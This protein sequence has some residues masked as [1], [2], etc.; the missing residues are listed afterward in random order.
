MKE[1]AE[2]NIHEPYA[3]ALRFTSDGKTLITTGMDNLI[4]LWSVGDWS[5]RNTITGHSKSANTL[6]LNPGESILASGS[7]DHT[8]RLWSFPDGDPQQT[9]EHRK[10][11]VA[12]VL[13]TTDG[14]L[15]ASGWYGGYV[16]VWSL[17]DNEQILSIKANDRHVNSLDISQDN[18]IMATS[19]IGDVIRLW[20]LPSGEPAGEL[21]GHKSAVWSLTFIEGGSTL[22]SMGY[23][24]DVVLWDM[25][26]LK[27]IK[28]FSIEGEDP[29]GV[30]VSPDESLAAV[31]MQGQVE[32]RQMADWSLEETLPVSSKVVHA[33]AFSPDGITIVA[34]GGDGKLRVWSDT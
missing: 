25:E 29:R 23:E 9:F 11:T 31:P 8:V 20:N 14:K 34:S 4:K 17:D 12:A 18:T 7:S 27:E 21:S 13:F 28:R 16:A 19:G 30:V 10:Q 15:L 33:A 6:D 26:T 5:L 3:L 1:T 22:L 2:F 24:R 32:L